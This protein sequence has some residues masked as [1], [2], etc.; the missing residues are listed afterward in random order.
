MDELDDIYAQITRL[1]GAGMKMK[2]IAA[3]VDY[4]PSVFSALYTTVIPA[5]RKNT[6]KGM[7]PAEALDAALAW[8][9]NVSKKRLLASLRAMRATLAAVE[10]PP[11]APR[12]A[13]ANPYAAALQRIMETS[14]GRVAPY[15]GIYMTYSVSS[16]S[17]AMKLEPYM[18]APSAC[19]AYAE[20]T[21]NSAYGTTH[22]GLVM[23]NGASHIYLMF[24]ESGGQR[25]DLFSVCLALPMYER[26]PFLRG[27]YTCFDYNYNPIARRILFVK[28]SDS[29]SSADFAAMRGCLKPP[30]GLDGEERAY[31]DYTCGPADVVR[32]CNVPSPTMGLADLAEEKRLLDAL[33]PAR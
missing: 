26:P 17:H 10:T 11:A 32:L 23:M 20:V 5:Y 12:L 13:A 15:C 4:P 6:A 25:L 7:A 2:D 30:A 19:G 33:R 29:T 18:I 21:H 8:V 22:R 14:A 24:N 9:N 16:G 31:Y 1:R 3:R 27:V 28:V